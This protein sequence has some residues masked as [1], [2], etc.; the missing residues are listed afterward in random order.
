MH[1]T[2]MSANAN[3]S[4]ISLSAITDTQNN[5]VRNICYRKKRLTPTTLMTA[6]AISFAVTF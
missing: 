6:P 5:T 2:Y 3:I 1:D 4:I